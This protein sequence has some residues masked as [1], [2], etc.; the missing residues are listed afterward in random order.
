MIKFTT[1]ISSTLSQTA[2]TGLDTV[3]IQLL[4]T[5]IYI[6]PPLNPII[7]IINEYTSSMINMCNLWKFDLS[8]IS[9]SGGRPFRNMSFVVES[10]LSKMLQQ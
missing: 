9:G 4:N 10:L 2:L 1:S 5:S 7:P 6:F 8:R 3:Q